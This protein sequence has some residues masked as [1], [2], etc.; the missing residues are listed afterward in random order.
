MNLP[1]HLLRHSTFV[2]R[3]LSGNV[4]RDFPNGRIE[5]RVDPRSSC[6]MAGAIQGPARIDRVHAAQHQITFAN[7]AQTEIGFQI[8]VNGSHANLGV[9]PFECA[10]RC[11]RLGLANVTFTEKHTA[12]EV[13]DFN[14][15]EVHDQQVADSEQGQ[16]L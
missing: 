9:Q 16:I 1:P 15:V 12:G 3:A 13:G 10:C 8:T 14:A 4:E 11:G 7:L 5:S 6:L 2:A